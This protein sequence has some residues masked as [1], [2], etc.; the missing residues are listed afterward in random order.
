MNH[1]TTLTKTAPV[2]TKKSYA[3]P[4]RTYAPLIVNKLTVDIVIP[5]LNEAAT[6]EAQVR[7]LERY[8]SNHASFAYRIIIADNGSVD[9]TRTIAESLTKEHGTVMVRTLEKKGRGRALKKVWQESDADI[10]TYMDVDLST[11]LSS[12]IPLITPLIQG[13]AGIAIGTRLHDESRTTRSAKREIISRVYNRIIRLTSKT[14][15]SDAQCGF[16]AIRRDVALKL[17]PAVKDNEW[18]FDTELLIKA[19]RKN[20]S[21][22]EQ[23]VTWKEDGDSRVK[24]VRTALQDL[25]GL[26]RVNAELDERSWIERFALPFILLATFGVYLFGALQNDLANSYYSAAVQAASADWKAWFFGSLDAAN[27]ITVDKPPLAIQVMALSARIFG[28]SS[29]S[30]LLPGVLAG[31]GSVWLLYKTVARQFG[32]RSGLIAA[33]L[34]ALTPVSALMFGFN[35]PDALLTFMLVASGYA[36][37]RSLEQR[38]TLLWLGLAGLFTGLA[39]NVKMLQGLMLLPAFGLVYLLFAQPKLPVRLMHMAFAGFVTT[40]CTFAWSFVVSLVPASARPYIGS[41]NDNN[42]WSLIFGYNGFGRFFGNGNGQGGGGMGPG[43]TGFGGD[44]GVFR[45]FNA[46]FGPN[47][48]WWLL[49]ALAGATFLVWLLRRTPR[50]NRARAQVVFW[51]VWI[52]THLVIFSMTEGVIH[53]YYVVVMAPAIA[54]LVGIGIPF[55]VTAYR[56]RN[57]YWWVLPA[58]VFM[59][60]IIAIPLA[61]Y[62]TTWPWLG[63]TVAALATVGA[64]GLA[65]GLRTRSWVAN[66]AL[67]L[68]LGACLL[69]PT[70]YTVATVSASH[71]GSIPTSGPT[72]TAMAG[73]NN[74]QSSASTALIGYLTEHRQNATWLVAVAS[75]NQSAAIQITSGQ[76]VMAIGGFNGSDSALTLDEFKQ[77]VQDGKVRY[78]LVSQ[79]GRGGGPG[80]GNDDIASWVRS[81]GTVI[82]YGGNAGTLYE[83]GV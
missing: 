64:A 54:A 57:Q 40:I 27:Y 82:D 42:I 78:Y 36:F 50:D 44:T 28:F 22:H 62:V 7:R 4:G 15:F 66:G 25:K 71:T 12:F 39:F 59:T 79:S 1:S 21:I 20:I 38:N 80:M 60:G 70:M 65:L 43:G 48:A 33:A 5:V 30:M 31:V 6:L 11:D 73:S 69:A 3:H 74:E 58:T 68:S 17:L 51:T 56:R 19:E 52:L 55:M 47:I 75:A 16:K 26:V 83:L 76:P 13:R 49:A 45:I 81:S 9:E 67:A 63:W 72:A 53:P 24:I 2:A 32:G 61:G 46:D 10:L 37:I 35:N 34:L 23:P 8:M 18:F 14:T 29:F 41:T 77:L